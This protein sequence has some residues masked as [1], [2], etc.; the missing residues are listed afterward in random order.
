[1]S[2]YLRTLISV[3]LLFPICIVPFFANEKAVNHRD[4]LLLSLIAI[5]YS[6]SYYFAFNMAVYLLW[7]ASGIPKACIDCSAE[8]FKFSS[9]LSSAISSLHKF[10]HGLA[11]SVVLLYSSEKLLMLRKMPD[12]STLSPRRL[13][14][15]LSF[16]ITPHS[17]PCKSVFQ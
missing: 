2:I 5:E 1:M 13:L 11:H 3:L 12:A 9:A 16:L 15:F 8:S 14:Y 7:S 6:V 4:L 10:F 17:K